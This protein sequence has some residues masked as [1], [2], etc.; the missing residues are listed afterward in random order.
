M[1]SNPSSPS[2]RAADDTSGANSTR[3]KAA[4]IFLRLR[5]IR[6]RLTA[7]FVA[8]FGTTLIL[9]SALLY[10]KFIQ[11][12]QDEFDTALYNHAVDVAGAIDINLFGDLSLRS[13]IL[14]GGEKLLPFS[15]GTSMLQIKAFD[16]PTLARSRNLGRAEL[17]LS[18]TDV[19][20]LATRGVSIRTIQWPDGKPY[21][22][23]NFVID[24]PPVQ[25]LI[26]QIAVSTGFLDREQV[27]LLTFFMISIPAILVIA[28]FG[29]L[30]LS[31]RALSPVA[32]IIEKTRD[33]Q[34]SHLSERVPVPAERDEIQ[35]LAL[36][37][38]ELLNRLQQAFESQERFVADASHQLKTPLSILRGELDVLRMRAPTAEEML[39]FLGSASQEIDYLSRMVEDLLMLARV[40]AGNGA[41]A[42]RR[43]RFDEIA[44]E[45]ASRL[46]PL[47]RKKDVKVRFNLVEADAGTGQTSEH[48]ELSG[49][50]DLLQ[51][52]MHN[53]IENAVKYSPA[54]AT[55]DVTLVD[56]AERVVAMVK[57][58][59]PGIPPE[60]LSQI[61]ERFFRASAKDSAPGLG[62][63]LPI[64][65]R[66]AEAHGGSLTVR[67]DTQE[68]TTFRLEILKR[69]V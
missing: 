53:L 13:R 52:V 61:F 66:I 39:T 55:V 44:L 24:K 46:E 30:F 59:G 49:D 69:R 12:H 50:P 67:S 51:S 6:F 5:G 1:S 17:P 11:T 33:I 56:E 40:D 16:G 62:L 37:L 34:A 48:F 31:R 63:G 14:S 26:L 20:Q 18:P 60:Q 64:A 38:N 9:F 36:T 25:R 8:I 45:A 29:G 28:T 19:Q 41:L 65:R 27:Q 2:H 10:E 54:A 22:L 43:L 58:P 47:A 3:D 4:P 23:L 57:N 35:Q 42:I 15:L 7:L 32:A 68:G 21:R